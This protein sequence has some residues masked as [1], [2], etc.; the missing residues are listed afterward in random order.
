MV[1]SRDTELKNDLRCESSN[2]QSYN[3]SSFLQIT[4][5]IPS[6]DRSGN[7]NLDTQVIWPL[8]ES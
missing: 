3:Q 6:F 5:L 1:L 8:S 4:R 7:R 2:V